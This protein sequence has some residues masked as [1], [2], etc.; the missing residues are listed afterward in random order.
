MPFVIYSTNG[1][2]LSFDLTRLNSIV[3]RL[4]S[5]HCALS[6]DID[7]SSDNDRSVDASDFPDNLTEINCNNTATQYINE[8]VVNS[9]TAI[10]N[11]S[12]M[13]VIEG[14]DNITSVNVLDLV[15]GV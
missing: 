11:K 12:A 15:V 4:L 10:D 13:D 9:N 7:Q 8:I 14:S 3:F 2:W 1:L 6:D 5:I